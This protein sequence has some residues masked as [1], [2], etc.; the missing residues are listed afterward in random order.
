MESSCTMSSVE[1]AFQSC[2]SMGRLATT[3]HA[4]ASLVCL[5]Q[6]TELW[7]TVAGTTI[8]IQ[9]DCGPIIQPSSR[10]KTSLHSSGSLILGRFTSL[11]THTEDTRRCGLESSILSWFER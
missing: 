6:R 3:L 11:D 1:R 10:L 4:S 5:E 9:T 7:R 2:S 8:R